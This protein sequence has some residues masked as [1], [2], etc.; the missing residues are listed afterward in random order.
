MKNISRT[1]KE[2]FVGFIV[3]LVVL[4]VAGHVS[5]RTEHFGAFGAGRALIVFLFIFMLIAGRISATWAIFLASILIWGIGQAMFWHADIATLLYEGSRY[6]VL[7]M[8]LLLTGAYLSLPKW[9][10]RLYV[11]TWQLFIFILVAAYAEMLFG[12]NWPN[13]QERQAAQVFFWNE[14]DLSAALLVFSAFSLCVLR[15][16]RYSLFV[17]VASFF[18]MIF[19]DSK[20]ALLGLLFIFLARLLYGSRCY[21]RFKTD[22]RVVVNIVSLFVMLVFVLLA[23]VM[24]IEVYGGQWV[25]GDMIKEAVNG[26][27]NVEYT[28]LLTGSP[29]DRLNA[30]I[31]GFSELIRSYGL[32][33]GIGGGEVA[34]EKQKEF[35]GNAKSLHNFALQLVVEFGMFF[36]ILGLAAFLMWRQRVDH[37]ER[38]RLNLIVMSIVFSGVSQSAGFVNNFSA[39]LP[40]VV[41]GALI[42]ERW[43]IRNK[44]SNPEENFGA[45]K[46][47]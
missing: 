24:P 6:T 5:L 36:L 27:V 2:F 13:I 45:G 37:K 23:S 19:N 30:S 18:I 25:L 46:A 38:W 31:L 1:L 21:E 29:A 26:V 34:I 40:F 17:C 44:I 47:F 14:N 39:W 16:L 32:G 28:A 9:R 11:V 7:A 43:P 33:V 4:S 42:A 22:A 8:M 41:G 10:K 20:A 35:F 15:R 12:F 3:L